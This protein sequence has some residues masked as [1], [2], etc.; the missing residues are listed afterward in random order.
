[1]EESLKKEGADCSIEADTDPE[2]PVSSKYI[3]DE[4]FVAN[5][6]LKNYGGSSDSVFNIQRRDENK[7]Y[8]YRDSDYKSADIIKH[9]EK[10]FGGRNTERPES[11]VIYKFSSPKAML[12][13]IEPMVNSGYAVTRYFYEDAKKGQAVYC[14]LE[15]SLN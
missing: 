14:A 5:K 15:R 2:T 13:A 10:D 11:K 8:Y 1:M 7:K 4:G 12:L 3:E 9:Y 6:V